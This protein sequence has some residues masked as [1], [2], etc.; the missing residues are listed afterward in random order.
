M[1]KFKFIFLGVLLCILFIINI[2]NNVNAKD[3]YIKLKTDNV[4]YTFK[5][6]GSITTLYEVK[7]TINTIYQ[8][9]TN[10]SMYFSSTVNRTLRTPINRG[11]S[12]YNII[13]LNKIGTNKWEL[14]YDIALSNSFITE[15][16][17]D[18][19]YILTELID[20]YAEVIAVVGEPVYSGEQPLTIKGIQG[21]Y[22]YTRLVVLDVREFELIF[23]FP[24]TLINQGITI[25]SIKIQ[26]ITTG[27]NYNNLVPDYEYYPNLKFIWTL[28]DDF[29]QEGKNSVWLYGINIKVGGIN[30]TINL[31]TQLY[32]TV[33]SSQLYTDIYNEAKS[34]SYNDGYNNGYEEAYNF[35]Y[36]EGYN[37][38]YEVGDA[39]G[40]RRGY[41]AGVNDEFDVF[42]YLEALFGEQGLGRLL[43]IELLPHVTIGAIVIIPLMFFLVSFIWR[44]FR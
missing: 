16:S 20:I 6:K 11:Y 32:V 14:R 13:T 7:V 35:G 38:G 3:N 33:I 9:K 29:F 12:S 1:R 27:I 8:L 40:Y 23:N 41:N 5:D 15:M 39:E 44:W 43:S 21:N 26:N 37:F 24:E 34:H 2:N 10:V 42:K 4:S 31:T 25:E 18:I 17:N 30:E 22:N 28:D 36:D 19:D